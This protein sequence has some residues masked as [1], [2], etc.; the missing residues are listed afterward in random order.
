MLGATKMTF[1]PSL[2]FD[3]CYFIQDLSLS[4]FNFLFLENATALSHPL[5]GLDS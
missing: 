2:W 5:T 3:L 4:M 1:H